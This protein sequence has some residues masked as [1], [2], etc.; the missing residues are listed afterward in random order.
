MPI[1]AAAFTGQV[2][3]RKPLRA[4]C[5]ICR[6]WHPLTSL[7]FLK[8]LMRAHLFPPA[9]DATLCFPRLL[10]HPIL[11]LGG[12]PPTLGLCNHP[13]Y[14]VL[15]FNSLLCHPLHLLSPSPCH[16]L[17]CRDL[18]ILFGS[19]HC[20]PDGPPT[21]RLPSPK[22]RWWASVGAQMRS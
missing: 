10:S 4:W 16:M 3:G 18:N 21:L 13:C 15:A 20:S 17:G 1:Q 5:S 14:Q 22:W 12:Y 6:W 2:S 11:L 8:A 7:P 9:P 19:P